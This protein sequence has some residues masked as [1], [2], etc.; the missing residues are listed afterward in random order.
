MKRLTPFY[1]VLSSLNGN[2]ARLNYNKRELAIKYKKERDY[3][4]ISRRD[5]LDTFRISYKETD[6]WIHSQHKIR[7]LAERLTIEARL[8]IENYIREHPSFLHS[9]TPLIHD[10]FSP[11]I[12]QEMMEAGKAASVGPMAAV[13]GA[14]ARY[15][16]RG[17]IRHFKD[18]NMHETKKEPQSQEIIIENG[19]DCFLWIKEACL[20]SIWAGESPF[21]NKIA[22]RLSPNNGLYEEYGVCT[23]SGKIGHSLSLGIADAVTIVSHSSTLSDAVATMAGN[24]VKGGREIK[25]A[26]NFIDSLKGEGVLGGV[27]I[28]GDKIGAIGNI[29]LKVL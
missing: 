28:I 5:G 14:I 10:P 21:S 27:V 24:M 15:V 4:S 11:P 26:L 25:S 3:R 29:E 13:A 19:G 1:H 17:I 16:G 2:D 9:M 22:L 18:N 8:L 7:P 6:L 23:S 20:V 12:V